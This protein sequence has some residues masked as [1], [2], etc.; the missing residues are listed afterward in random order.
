M[1]RSFSVDSIYLV[2]LLIFNNFGYYSWPR[3]YYLL[4]S[5]RANPTSKL[6]HVSPTGIH[7]RVNLWVPKS[8][9]KYSIVP[10]AKLDVE[11]FT[12]QCTIY[13]YMVN[14]AFAPNYGTHWFF[15]FYLSINSGL[16]SRN[17]SL[18]ST[19]WP[20]LFSRYYFFGLF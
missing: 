17:S 14:F 4:I 5:S 12:T 18:K 13:I 7:R 3:S 11:V 8:W 9:L 15:F 19:V 1:I 16:K 10:A 2:F 20:S 6:S